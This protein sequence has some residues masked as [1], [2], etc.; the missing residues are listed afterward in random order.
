MD[1]LY[2]Y[3]CK[4]KPQPTHIIFIK[5]FGFSIQFTFCNICLKNVPENPCKFSFSN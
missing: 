1:I 3:G 4:K 2:G 5:K